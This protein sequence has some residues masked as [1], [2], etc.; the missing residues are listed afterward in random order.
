MPDEIVEHHFFTK[1]QYLEE[2]SP[3]F[4]SNSPRAPLHGSDYDYLLFRR[5]CRLAG[6]GKDESGQR[7]PCV[8]T[9]ECIEGIGDGR[10]RPW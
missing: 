4:R 3:E 7:W 5:Y 6:V 1:G 10:W 9:E 8:G 2:M